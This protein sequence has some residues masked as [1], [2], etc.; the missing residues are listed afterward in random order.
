[1]HSKLI[2]QSPAGHWSPR[3]DSNGAEI[4]KLFDVTSKFGHVDVAVD[5]IGRALKKKLQ[6]LQKKNTLR[7]ISPQFI[8]LMLNRF[9]LNPK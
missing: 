3:Q 9:R 5:N 6:N 4:K 2:S 1:V 7:C 8:V